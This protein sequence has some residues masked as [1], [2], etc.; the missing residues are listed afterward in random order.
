MDN[1]TLKLDG[2]QFARILSKFTRS[3]VSQALANKKIWAGGEFEFKVKLWDKHRLDSDNWL[4]AVK[5]LLKD[6][7]AKAPFDPTSEVKISE[8][9][10][11]VPIKKGQKFWAIE[12]DGSLGDS[13]LELKSPIMRL[14]DFMKVLP[15][16]FDWIDQCGGYTDNDCGLHINM[17][18][19]GRIDLKKELDIVKLYMFTEEPILDKFFKKR[20]NT[21]Y[22][23]SIKNKIRSEGKLT[24]GDVKE[25]VNIGKLN[26]ALTKSHRE[27]INIEHLDKQGSA[28]RIEFRYV[29]HA[30]YHNKLKEVQYSIGM[31]AFQMMLAYDPQFKRKE[32]IL[33]LIREIN[34]TEKNDD[35]G[36]KE[37]ND[38]EVKRVIKMLE[39]E[40]NTYRSFWTSGPEDF[41]FYGHM[42]SVHPTNDSAD[43]ENYWVISKAELIEYLTELL[44]D[45]GSKEDANISEM[46]DFE[47]FIDKE[48][49]ANE[50]IS[51]MEDSEYSEAHYSP[52]YSLDEDEEP[53]GEDGD[54]SDDQRERAGELAVAL[55]EERVNEDP[56]Y[57]I[58]QWGEEGFYN[59]FFRGNFD[60]EAWAE[61]TARE[62]A[63]ENH[64]DQVHT[65]YGG[66]DDLFTYKDAR[67]EGHILIFHV[68]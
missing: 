65:S 34:K 10:H 8:R 23:E 58:R 45:I 11:G 62:Y 42:I 51:E 18:F 24:I 36:P 48:S 54:W 60:Y 32:Y 64:L 25:L 37:L 5:T 44:T 29:G 12:P 19:A 43:V 67:S 21:A 40:H 22:V 56:I 6:Y 13:G 61:K 38:L 57:Y 68:Y 15:K 9:Y 39:A 49:L 47:E 33:K 17:S 2:K 53:E 63:N 41:G 35:V 50:I 27:A 7:G 55:L 20:L 30:N 28:Q 26:K 14:P 31:F 59:R 16:V 3:D 66:T 52:E 1:L 4:D 46:D